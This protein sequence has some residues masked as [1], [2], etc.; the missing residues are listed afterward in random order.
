MLVA[1]RRLP[2]DEAV[3]V[4]GLLL[5]AVLLVGPRPILAGFAWLAAVTPRLVA[6]DM[7]R[8]RLPDAIVLPGY[9]VVLGSVALDAWAQGTEPTGPPLAGAAY[10]LVL[11]L[12]HV[13]GGMGLGDVKLAPLLGAL[14]GA[15]APGGTLLA[16][17][18]AFLAGGIAAVVVLVRHGLGA[19][20]PFGPA[21]LF[22]AWAAVLV[23]A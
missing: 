3:P 19:R 5:V 21:M 8:H 9:P 17:V 23:L 10:G 18:L 2:V 4:L 15:I 1:A 20:M 16:V 11:L 22:G 6:V 14:T 7:A 13:L 12:L